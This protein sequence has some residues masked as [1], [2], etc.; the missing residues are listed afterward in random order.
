MAIRIGEIGRADS[1]RWSIL[2]CCDRRS[3]ALNKVGIG[4]IYVIHLE[5][6]H[7]LTTQRGKGCFANRGGKSCTTEELQ[8]GGSH[9]EVRLA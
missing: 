3:T 9:I 1:P 7:C 6:E 2:G 4:S 5:I 8:P